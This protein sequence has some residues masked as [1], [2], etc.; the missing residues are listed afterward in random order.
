ME[1]KEIAIK[2]AK[3]ASEVILSFYQ[4]VH[5]KGEEIFLQKQI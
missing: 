2:A 3:E 5:V 4:E 1:L